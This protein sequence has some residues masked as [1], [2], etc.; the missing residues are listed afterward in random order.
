MSVIFAVPMLTRA[1]VTG[2]E[3]RTGFVLMHRDRTKTGMKKF[4]DLINPYSKSHVLLDNELQSLYSGVD[5]T[6]KML[7][8]CKYI[9]KNN[10]DLQKIF[11][12]SD[13]V[14]EMFNEKTINISEISKLSKSEKNKKIIEFFENNLKNESLND[15]IKKLMHGV[16]KKAGKTVKNGIFSFARGM[17]SVPAAITTF[18]ISP[19][20]LGWIIPRLTYANTRRIHNKKIEEERLNKLNA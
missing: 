14:N 9:D 1:F 8:F 4:L 7:N 16:E 17:N 15:S 3:D 20:L 11:S 19:F 2:Y 6:S 12:K 5:N 18:A 13:F 10:G